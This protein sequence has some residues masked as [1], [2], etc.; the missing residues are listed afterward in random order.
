MSTKYAESPE[1]ARNYAFLLL[2]FR[3]RSENEIRQRLKKKKFQ[4]RI[5]EET[6]AFLKE[7]RFIDDSSFARAWI[8]SRLKKPLGMRRLREELRVKGISREIIEN[9]I[10]EAKKSYCEEDTVKKI[11]REKWSKLKG[12]DPL[13]AKRRIY[14]YLLRRGFFPQT[15]MESLE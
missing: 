13:K 14:S 5:I 1:K 11:I 9:N 4:P 15:I 6:I 7:R 3:L 12:I 8:S 2:K 10:E